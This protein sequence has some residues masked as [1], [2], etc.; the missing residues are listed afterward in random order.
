[1]DKK[2]IKELETEKSYLEKEFKEMRKNQNE[3][4]RSPD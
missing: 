2:Q 1:M 4:K 3:P